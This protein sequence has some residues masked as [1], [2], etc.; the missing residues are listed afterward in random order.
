AVAAESDRIPEKE[1]R[2]RVRGLEIGLLIPRAAAAREHVRRARVRRSVVLLIAV[3]SGGG[4][5]FANRADDQLIAVAAQADRVPE[6]IVRTG[7]RGFYVGLLRPAAGSAN[8]DIHGAGAEHRMIVLVAVDAAGR[9]LFHRRTD[10]QRAAVGAERGRK[11]ELRAG[12]RIRGL[13]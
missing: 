11:P 2:H 8:V 9:A 12:A 5:I 10:R 7:I 1:V 3:H 4:A 6:L 13:D